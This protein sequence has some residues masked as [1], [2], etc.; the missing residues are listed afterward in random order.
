MRIPRPSEGTAIEKGRIGIY[1]FFFLCITFV[2]STA[3]ILLPNFIADIAREDAW[4]SVILATILAVITVLLA[5]KIRTRMGRR[6]LI[7]TNDV[8][9]GSI[10]GRIF[11]LLFIIAVFNLAVLTICELNEIMLNAFLMKTPTLAISIMMVLVAAYGVYHG[12]EVFCRV[13]EI[14]L[15]LG[16]VTLGSVIVLNVGELNF[17]YFL[18][19]FYNGIMPSVRGALLLYGWIAQVSV[20]VYMISPFVKATA[21]QI[22]NYAVAATV[23]LGMMMMTGVL[24][25]AVFGANRTAHLQFPALNL[26]RYIDL[27]DFIQRL[28]TFIFAIWVGGV[29]IRLIVIYYLVTLGIRQFFCMEKASNI[30]IIVIGIAMLIGSTLI[31]Q[32]VIEL[33]Q[34]FKI[35]YPVQATL[36][37][38]VAPVFI[39]GIAYIRKIKPKT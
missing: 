16:L 36:F 14:L 18:P 33:I 28:D 34:I 3:D 1:Q 6:N 4:I 15:P 23:V 24:T 22:R 29:A 17:T 25:I 35:L 31:N 19:V 9:L 2:I 8:L 7:D 26:V 39:L 13:N 21:K 5:C 32:H 37:G 27:F 11:S 38:L 20:I 12:L 10:L 30:L